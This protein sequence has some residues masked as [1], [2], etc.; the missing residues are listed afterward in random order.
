MD[1]CTADSL[2]YIPKTNNVFFAMS[3]TKLNWSSTTIS[4]FKAILGYYYVCEMKLRLGE[5]KDV[6]LL[7]QRIHTCQKKS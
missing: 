3:S 5:D 2:W 1:N 6:K 7:Q 4:D